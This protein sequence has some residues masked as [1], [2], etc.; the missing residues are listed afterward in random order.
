MKY[1]LILCIVATILFSCNKQ[2]NMDMEDLLIGEWEQLAVN[3]GIATFLKVRKLD[4]EDY[5]I[6]F[7]NE[8]DMY[9]WTNDCCSPDT[10]DGYLKVPATYTLI[11]SILKFSTWNM[12]LKILDITKDDLTL[13]Y[14]PL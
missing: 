8:V 4:D 2:D 7:E 9:E 14:L 5:G 13:E 6:A 10:V 1:S 12:E 11:D 3:D